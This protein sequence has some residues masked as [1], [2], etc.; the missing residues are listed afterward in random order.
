MPSA[1][2]I[3]ARR[4]RSKKSGKNES[5]EFTECEQQLPE[6]C[7]CVSCYCDCNFLN[8]HAMLLQL[9][10][11]NLRSQCAA[12]AE[13][14][15]AT[16]LRSVEK[17]NPA[18]TKGRC[19]LLPLHRPANAIHSRTLRKLPQASRQ[20]SPDA[21]DST[22]ITRQKIARQEWSSFIQPLARL[23]DTEKRRYNIAHPHTSSRGRL[24][25]TTSKGSR[26]GTKS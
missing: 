21:S 24:S 6:C 9:A 20:A 8:C 14:S 17:Q 12:V 7:G 19:Y 15:A 4:R 22:N 10:C 16:A 26:M 2:F 23:F 5:V 11:G 18:L 1:A 13:S 25:M 3:A